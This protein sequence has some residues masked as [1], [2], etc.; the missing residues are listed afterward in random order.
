MID[1][2][3]WR[4]P[5]AGSAVLLL[6]VGCADIHVHLL[7]TAESAAID[8]AGDTADTADTAADDSAAPVRVWSAGTPTRLVNLPA[9]SSAGLAVGDL[10]ADGHPDLLHV[11]A[12]SSGTSR[13]THWLAAPG[14]ATASDTVDVPLTLTFPV[15][16]DLDG[17]G[18]PELVA[19]SSSTVVRMRLDG[20]TPREPETLLVTSYGVQALTV[21]EFTG[22]GTDDLAVLAWAAVPLDATV[23]TS[24]GGGTLR[25]LGPAR[26]GLDALSGAFRVPVG[27]VDRLVLTDGTY[28]MNPAQVVDVDPDAD[29][30][31]A[32]RTLGVLRTD[33]PSVAG[34]VDVDIDGDGT[35]ELVT[36]AASGL[37]AW[38][39]LDGA[40]T[41]LRSTDG[42]TDAGYALAAADLEGDGDTELVE[43]RSFSESTDHS[44]STRISLSVAHPTDAGV[45]IGDPTVFDLGPLVVRSALALIDLDLDGCVDLVFL[46]SST[47]PWLSPGNCDPE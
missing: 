18:A 40:V 43:L 27:G 12:G 1:P 22:D 34:L 5:E 19:D 44:S 8:S 25:T 45:T 26:A 29:P 24:H 2:A 14:G 30:A 17:D 15:L 46:D 4:Q 32:A 23:V 36:T 37:Q 6:L 20:G 38:N 33:A 47:E 9:A 31:L 16:A 35:A 3:G 41:V 10:D 11:S 39:P 28:T 21:G 42:T 13:L 7:D